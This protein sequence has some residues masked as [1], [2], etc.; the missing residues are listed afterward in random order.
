MLKHICCIYATV[1]LLKY[2]LTLCFWKENVF[3]V[4]QVYTLKYQEHKA[5]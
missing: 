4:S 2:Y 3:K 5:V 1:Y